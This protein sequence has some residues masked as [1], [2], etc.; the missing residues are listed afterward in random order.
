MEKNPARFTIDR[1]FSVLFYFMS[2]EKVFMKAL[3]NTLILLVLLFIALVVYAYLP[4]SIS[5]PETFAGQNSHFITLDGRT[6]H[7]TVQGSGPALVLVHGFGG[8]T[9]AWTK[10]TGY[11]KEQY[12]VYALDLLG[13]G[14]SDKPSDASYTLPAQADIVCALIKKL[15]LEQAVLIGHSMGGVIVAD[16]QAKLPGTI[17]GI[18]MIEPGFYFTPPAF[19]KSLFFPFDRAMA[20]MFYSRM[21]REKSFAASYLDTSLI[22]PEMIDELLIARHTPGAVE[23]MQAMSSDP[24]V[25]TTYE[26]IA[27]AVTGPSLM[28]WGERGEKT[29]T[30]EIEDTKGLI[31]GVQVVMVDKSGH[32]VQ[33]EKPKQ[34]VRAI[35]AFL[36]SLPF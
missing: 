29:P 20:K 34:C 2:P 16:T 17:K 4:Y 3:R 9:L 14:L 1:L 33:D 25:Y 19:L 27:A 11:L 26:D 15:G 30:V 7:Y 35:L 21:G 23:A 10:L 32:Y 18:V 31:K 8:S 24:A 12:T 6:I 13:F 36:Q 5:E 22:T 28:I